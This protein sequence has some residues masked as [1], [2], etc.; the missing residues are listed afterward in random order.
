ME[1]VAENGFVPGG[2]EELAPRL[3]V[4]LGREPG[5]TFPIPFGE[6]SLGRDTDCRITLLDPSVSRK[7]ARLVRA[8]DGS[9]TV[10]DDSSTNGTH[11][12]D[13]KV[14]R[15]A[16]SNG[17]I[18]RVGNVL[19]KFY[20]PGTIEAEV[21]QRV[22]QMAMTDPLTGTLTKAAITYHLETMVANDPQRLAIIMADL[23]HFKQVN[24]TYGHMAG[25][26]VL[27]ELAGALKTTALRTGD[28]I[29]RFGGEEFLIILP[30]TSLETACQV[31]ETA[32]QAV[33]QATTRYKDQTIRMTSSFGVTIWQATDELQPNPPQAMLERADQAMYKAKKE[34]RNRY[35]SIV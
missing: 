14:S 12:N 22:F 15:S 21:F 27:K 30:E 26:L 35:C 4:I 9:V 24:D 2:D 28:L 11:V 18:L 1:T 6:N 7:H 25:D 20:E 17:D 16:L 31:A 3:M 34:G 29:G 10:V 19:L 23:D 8:E 13:R 32:R 5:K 33:E